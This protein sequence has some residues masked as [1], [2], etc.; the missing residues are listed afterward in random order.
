MNANERITLDDD[1]NENSPC[2]ADFYQLF[3]RIVFSGGEHAPK[4]IMVTSAREGEGKS[5]LASYVSFTAALSTEN[6]HLLVDGD[7]RRPSVHKIF[8]VERKEG[9]SDALMSEK[10][11]LGMIKKTVNKNLHILTA[12]RH[13]AHPLQL[14]SLDKTKQIFKQLES[15]YRMIIIDGPPVIPVGDTL[16]LAQL[17]DGVILVVRTGKTP[18]T[19]VKRAID[20]LKSS[21]CKLLGVALNDL[22]SVLPYYYQK[23][24]Y[25]YQYEARPEHS[26]SL[27]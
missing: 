22:S 7:L 6:F 24:Y 27:K 8:G 14:L 18:R 9:L 5:T 12:G 17:V 23:K 3:Y 11:V 19:V 10:A 13:V 25:R 15:Y 20:M 26:D 21:N 2:F 1:Y 16:R 4:T